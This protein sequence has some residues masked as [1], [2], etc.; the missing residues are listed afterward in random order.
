MTPAERAGQLRRRLRSPFWLRLFLLTRLPLAG[1]AGLR[2]TR[3]DDEACTVSVPY[4][5]R[6]QNPFRSIYFAAL[7]MAAEMSTGALCWLATEESGV[8]VAMLV[9][10]LEAS[11]GKK[12]DARTTFIC[13]QGAEISRAVQEAVATGEP[14]TVRVE[15]VGR[16]PDGAEVARFHFTWSFKAS[17]PRPAA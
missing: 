16:L 8:S 1:F 17:A 14:R 11:Y 6:S 15:T 3:L 12:A 13:E 5:W 2:V 4:G 10:G 9:V 7:A